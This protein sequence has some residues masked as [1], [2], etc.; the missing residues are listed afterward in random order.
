MAP[1]RR[2]DAAIKAGLEG[3]SMVTTTDR[4][5]RARWRLVALAAVL[6][7]L[8]AA[9]G[10]SAATETY[11]VGGYEIW[12]TAYAATFVG[13]TR[14]P[15]GA[16]GGW[17]ATIE[18]SGVISPTGS[19]SGGRAELLLTDRSSI[20]A[21]VSGGTVTL[22]GGSETE[23]AAMTHEVS[24]DLVDVVRGGRSTVGTGTLSATLVHY[25]AW[26]FGRCLTY[27]ASV[28]GTIALTF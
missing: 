20:R 17:R 19:I 24:A 23:C 9:P 13:T 8:L 7:S 1:E 5:R 15:A 2:Y 10:A 22:V 14:D 11:A 28:D 26:V 12:P 6:L 25:R 21:T 4:F 27:S 18:H 16:W 3:N